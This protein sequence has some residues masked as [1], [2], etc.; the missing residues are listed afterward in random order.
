MSARWHTD[1][2]PNERIVEVEWEGEAIRVLAFYG[3]NGWRPHWRSEDRT[4]M[5]DVDAFPRWR[6]PRG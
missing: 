1:K 5:W 4:K 2:P 3:R 6:Y